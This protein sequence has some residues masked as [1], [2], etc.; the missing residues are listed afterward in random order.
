MSKESKNQIRI[1]NNKY[2][3][4]TVV[5]SDDQPVVIITSDE[6]T[7]L[8]GYHALYDVGEDEGSDKN[9]ARR[10]DSKDHNND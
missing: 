6:I 2:K 9:D 7:E 1:G 10:K 3:N 5:D 8:N 4:I